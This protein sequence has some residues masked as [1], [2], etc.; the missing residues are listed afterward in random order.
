MK[1]GIVIAA[2]LL[3]SC[4]N[5]AAQN[6]PSRPVRMI[7]AFPAGGGTDAVARIVGQKL[8]VLWGQ[9][10]VVDNRAGAGGI[11]GAELAA[12]APPDG[13]TI[14]LATTGNLAINPGLYSKLPYDTLKDFA[15]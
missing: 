15:P 5:A 1:T 3:A 6:F 12:N 4:L 7:V 14:F 9:Q 8:T 13:Y 11:V 2:L 10:V